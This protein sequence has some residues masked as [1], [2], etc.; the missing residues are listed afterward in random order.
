[1]RPCAQLAK[2]LPCGC[3]LRSLREPSPDIDPALVMTGEVATFVHNILQLKGNVV[4]LL[5]SLRGEGVLPPR[6]STMRRKAHMTSISCTVVAILSEP[7]LNRGE[8][9]S[10]A[11]EEERH[12]P[13]RAC[14]QQQQPVAAAGIREVEAG[15]ER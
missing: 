4:N 5:N 11:H 12:P 14:L 7:M 3:A 1:M 6:E 15:R 10:I 8:R 9:P 2:P 13:R